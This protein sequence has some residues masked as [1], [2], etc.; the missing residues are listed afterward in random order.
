[1]SARFL[2]THAKADS[3]P[4]EVY[5]YCDEH[6]LLKKDESDLRFLLCLILFDPKG[7]SGVSPINSTVQKRQRSGHVP[8]EQGFR[9]NLASNLST[10]KTNCFEGVGSKRI[11]LQG[12]CGVCPV[13]AY[14]ATTTAKR[15]ARDAWTV[16]DLV[17]HVQI[18]ASVFR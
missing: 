3:E 5:A 14:E 1:M 9:I 17:V 4:R 6:A 11:K 8:G 12:S 10:E 2:V 15:G 18:V 16:C 7:T 13:T